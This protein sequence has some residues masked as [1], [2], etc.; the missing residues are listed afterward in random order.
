LSVTPTL[1]EIG[2]ARAIGSEQLAEST[3]PDANTA[4]ATAIQTFADAALKKFDDG[5]VIKA[6]ARDVAAS[7]VFAS[8][9]TSTK[10]TGE[11]AS[12]Q[13]TASTVYGPVFLVASI[14][15]V[16][17]FV[18]VQS[19]TLFGDKAS[20][21]GMGY[22]INTVFLMS[23]S[24]FL[25]GFG[26]VIV[27]VGSLVATADWT[28]WAVTMIPLF[29]KFGAAAFLTLQPMTALLTG[30]DGFGW[31]NLT[32][33]L[34]F[35]M[36]SCMSLS[37]GLSSNVITGSPFFNMKNPAQKSVVI[38]IVYVLG[39]ALLTTAN[40]V[41]YSGLAKDIPKRVAAFQL[42]GSVCLLIGSIMGMIP[43]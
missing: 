35:H 13:V 42:L 3:H 5:S 43:M 27:D 19:T 23:S 8:L 37:F 18:L 12:K 2:T 25:H 15:L 41:V 4:T 14:L 40:Y 9:M 17:A 7:Q 6:L 24:L 21:S 11:A 26:M 33:S 32:G 1:C 16:A 34:L 22:L 20:F 31:T 36:G 39:T 28:T 38:T 30:K 29:L 10:V